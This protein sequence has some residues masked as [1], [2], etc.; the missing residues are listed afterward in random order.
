MKE[1]NLIKR[2]F[3][4]QYSQFYCGLACLTSIVKYHGG[5]I[6]QEKLRETSGTTLQGT[7]LLGLYQSAQKLGFE[8][9]GYEADFENLKKM[10]APVILHI[11]KDGNLEHYVVCYGFE[12]GRFTIGD[13]C[14]WVA[15]LEIQQKGYQQAAGGDANLCIDGEQIH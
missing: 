4:K 8:V 14:F 3:T 10:E 9:K 11:L 1:H 2:T 15:G 13:P 7:S 5:E 6:T 12:A